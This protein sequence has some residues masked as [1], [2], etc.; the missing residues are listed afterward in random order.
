MPIPMLV[1]LHGCKQSPD[2]FAAGTRMNAL[3]EQHGFLVVYP[4]QASNANGSK[5]WNWF[6][7]QDQGRDSGEPSLIAGITREVASQY[8]IDQRRIFVAG[9]SAGAAMAVILGVTY[10]ELY[11]SVGA[12]S[13]LPY[14][15]AHDVSSAF[16]AMKGGGAPAGLTKSFASLRAHQPPIAN[17]VPTIVFHGDADSTVTVKDR[18]R[19]AASASGPRRCAVAAEPRTRGTSGNTQGDRIVN[20][21]ARKAS[22]GLV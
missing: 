13:G 8:R 17:T 22:A 18:I 12:H 2:D 21:P 5:C 16:S 20:A 7:S 19:P 15:A 14:A 9:L 4:A 10:P 11:A 3:A 1:M 6:R